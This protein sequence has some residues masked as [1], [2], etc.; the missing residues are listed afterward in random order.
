[1]G[2][3]YPLTQTRYGFRWGPV[4]VERTATDE[5]WGVV[6]TVKGATEQVDIRVSPAGRTLTVSEKKTAVHL[7]E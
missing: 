2:N 1:M 7:D 3:R 6:V 4:T 5:K